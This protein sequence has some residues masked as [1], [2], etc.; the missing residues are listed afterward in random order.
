MVK[1]I[2]QT[3]RLLAD[4]AAD[5]VKI[6]VKMRPA[7]NPIDMLKSADTTEAT[8]VKKVVVV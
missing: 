8:V 1:T 4:T 2:I 3:P 7:F 6:L 5:L